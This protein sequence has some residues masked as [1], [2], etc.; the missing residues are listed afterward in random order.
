MDLTQ[1]TYFGPPAIALPQKPGSS[2]QTLQLP[3]GAKAKENS[4]KDLNSQLGDEE[5]KNEGDSMVGSS[6]LPVAD[7][8]PKTHRGSSSG[9]FAIGQLDLLS[10]PLREDH[11]FGK[12]THIRSLSLSPCPFTEI[13]NPK[14]VALFNACICRFEKNFSLFQ[15]YVSAPLPRLRAC[16]IANATILQIKSKSLNQIHDFYRCWKQ[17]KYYRQWKLKSRER[18]RALA[19][20]QLLNESSRSSLSESSD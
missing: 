8:R 13:W 16:G 6:E 5:E 14:E 20:Q 15:N 2:P 3:S 17:T 4:L 9:L 10:N 12:C 7:G 19:T 11:P 18:A 1:L